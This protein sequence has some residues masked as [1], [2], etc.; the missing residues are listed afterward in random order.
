MNSNE[1]RQKIYGPYHDIWKL[2]KIIEFAGP[3]DDEIWNKYMEG[4]SAFQTAYPRTNKDG[5]YEGFLMSAL[6]EA[7][8]IIAKENKKIE[9]KM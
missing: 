8:D 6:L 7:A 5:T 9:K 3:D 2:I 1:F 4:I